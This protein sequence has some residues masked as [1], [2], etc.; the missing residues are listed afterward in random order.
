MEITPILESSPVA[1]AIAFRDD[2]CGLRGYI[3][4]DDLTLGPAAGG[5]RT[6]RYDSD[7]EALADACRL[8]GAMTLKCAIAGLDAGGG[9][10]VVI[11]TGTLD[12]PRAFARLG[13]L[14]EELEGS[15]YTAGD[16]GT[17]GADLQ[18]MAS[19]TGYVR[20]D[21]ADLS[22]AVARGLLR[23]IE[24]CAAVRGREV[25]G[26]R[27]A[28]QG[29]GA[30]G[31]AAARTLAAAG[32]RLVVADVDSSRAGALA[33]ELGAD[34]VGPDE[35]LRVDADIVAPCAIGGVLDGPA[36]AALRA[37]AVC[38]AANNILAAPDIARALADRDILHVP[39]WISSAG[40]VIDGVGE[41]IMELADR[42]PLIDQLGA[43]AR[44]VLDEAA[45]TGRT[46]SDVAEARARARI[47]AA[48]GTWRRTPGS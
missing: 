46:P 22:V 5:I 26:L 6:R 18:A 16:L 20:T 39:D 19:R 32:A 23:C 11:D 17:T 14:V 44:L 3:V 28:V 21:E 29:C 45:R 15:F 33:D 4:L 25:A 24:A 40:A 9:K 30:I 31:A 36:V 27:V 42:V 34:V 1:R 12:R 37:W 41:G 38:G 10:G 7:D 48:P 13:A 43:T 47:D 2:D 8:A 35:I